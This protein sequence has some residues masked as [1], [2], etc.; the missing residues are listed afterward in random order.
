MAN[1][2]LVRLRASAAVIPGWEVLVTTRR[3][4]GAQRRE[5]PGHKV[6]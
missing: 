1:A 4:F 6:T 2:V 5:T 3:V